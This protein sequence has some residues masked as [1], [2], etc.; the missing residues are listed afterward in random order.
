[1][2]ATATPKTD[3][4]RELKLERQRERMAELRAKRKAEKE[5]AAQAGS[6]VKVID[7]RTGEQTG[8]LV[9]PPTVV[10]RES[11][12]ETVARLHAEAKDL[13]TD[14]DGDKY[15]VYD[16]LGPWKVTPCCGCPVTGTDTGIAC[17][18]CYEDMSDFPDGPARL[19]EGDPKV[20]PASETAVRI[21][22]SDNNVATTPA[23]SEE[24]GAT[25]TSITKNKKAPAP[26]KATAKKAPPKK[27]VA[28]AAPPKKTA[29]RKPAKKAVSPAPHARMQP[30]EAPAPEV[31]E[32]GFHCPK[33]NKTVKVEFKAKGRNAC[34]PCYNAAFAEWKA[35][36]A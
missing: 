5:A 31:G 13:P 1:M 8:T 18:G 36:Q 4:M 25:V 17:K 14:L 15:R 28:K 12:E 6:E 19:Q 26:K 2:A 22:L 27:T 23:A 7:G 35:K 9:V 29:T 3:A 33:C 16:G 32:E 34:K 10:T 30:G 24:K 20:A 11:Y 21:D